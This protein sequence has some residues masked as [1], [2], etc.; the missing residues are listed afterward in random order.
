MP[1]CLIYLGVCLKQALKKHI[2]DT[3]FFDIK[4]FL[5]K[6]AHGKHI[7]GTWVVYIKT[8]VYSCFIK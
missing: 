2:S 3:W 7:S 4:V 6:Q 1:D 5:F 8:Y